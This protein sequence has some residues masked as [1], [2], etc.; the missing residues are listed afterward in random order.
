M[1]MKRETGS[2]R[3]R[4]NCGS[5]NWDRASVCGPVRL[6]STRQKETVGVYQGAEDRDQNENPER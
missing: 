1:I 2:C 4:P 5:A 6:G 3:V